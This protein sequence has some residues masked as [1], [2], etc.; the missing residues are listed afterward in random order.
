[1]RMT[2]A[3]STISTFLPAIGLCVSL[4]C[5][6]L[7]GRTLVSSDHVAPRARLI[8]CLRFDFTLNSIFGNPSCECEPST[9]HPVKVTA[10]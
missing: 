3:S 7:P 6:P 8:A 1:M 10:V 9:D 5:E 2:T 4:R